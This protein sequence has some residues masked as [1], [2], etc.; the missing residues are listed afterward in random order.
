MCNNFGINQYLMMAMQG[1]GLYNFMP[2]LNLGATPQYQFPLMQFANNFSTMPYYNFTNTSNEGAGGA[3]DSANN[4]LTTITNYMTSLGF[5][6]SNGY[7]VS[8]TSD[9]KLEY[10]YNKDGKSYT[11]SSLPELMT[12]MTTGTSPDEKVGSLEDSL[13]T[14]KPSNSEEVDDGDDTSREGAG[15]ADDDG[16]VHKGGYKK[17]DLTNV[18][19][20]DKALEWKG[21]K[22]CSTYVKN[23][24]KKGMT[25]DDL[26]DKMLP[27]AE[28]DTKATY[29]KWVLA[30]NPNGIK[31][32]K[33]AD[34]NK[35]D[36]P[37]YADKKATKPVKTTKKNNKRVKATA[38][39]RLHA[40]LGLVMT[41]KGTETQIAK[42]AP[43][44]PNKKDTT[45]VLTI[46]QGI[47]RGTWKFKDTNK[48]DMNSYLKFS[49]FNIYYGGR[50]STHNTKAICIVNSDNKKEYQVSCDEHGRYKVNYNEKDYPLEDLINS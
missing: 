9:G 43:E 41:K 29:K 17:E 15:D 24:I 34:L 14:V 7:A 25:I 11:A 47:L 3:N 46:N 35:L 13:T 33:V 6:A 26:V 28:D 40:S 8:Q 36:L 21:F 12:K 10:T 18:K 39:Q 45:A 30:A 23:N 5:T 19:I 32:G 31:D 49:D 4:N 37:V 16:V 38:I 44:D 2:Q 20:N 42:L 1:N 48:D 50:L 27:N 22:N